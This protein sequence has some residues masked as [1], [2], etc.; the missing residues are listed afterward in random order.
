MTHARGH[1]QPVNRQLICHQSQA[2]IC[3]E[4]NNLVIRLIVF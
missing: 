3:E 2:G 4:E 1:E